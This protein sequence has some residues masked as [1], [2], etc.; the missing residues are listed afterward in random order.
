VKGLSDIPLDF[1][2]D[3]ALGWRRPRWRLGILRAKQHQATD[4]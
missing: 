3:L 1:D 4:E 2:V